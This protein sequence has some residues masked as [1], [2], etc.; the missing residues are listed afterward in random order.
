ME[1]DLLTAEATLK[2][3]TQ[4]WQ[5]KQRLYQEGLVSR[6][7]L[8]NAEKEDRT[9]RNIVA[10]YR[11]SLKAKTEGMSVLDVMHDKIT[12]LKGDLAALRGKLRLTSMTENRIVAPMTGVVAELGYHDGDVLDDEKKILSILETDSI[13]LDVNVPEVLIKNIKV[14]A[15]AVFT[16]VFDWHK[17]YRGQVQEISHLV[18][19]KD[20]ET[21]FPVKVRLIDRDRYLVPYLNGKVKFLK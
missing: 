20:N 6:T 2:T 8:E 17:K 16:P 12:S 21:F 4:E 9:H 18:I 10:N 1:N 14:G 15:S 19:T 11:L 13:Y 7:E 5:D 3:V